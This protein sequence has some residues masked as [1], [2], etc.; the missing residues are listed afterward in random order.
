M[1]HGPMSTPFVAR[2]DQ[3]TVLLDALDRAGR[4][5]PGAVL[6][7]GDAG[8]GKSALVRHLAGLAGARGA[9]VV[10]AHCVDLGEIGLPYLP[11]AEAVARL[12]E[13]APEVVADVGRE[14]PALG[15]LLPGARPQ[16]PGGADGDRLQVFDA[17]A[18][19]LG[20]VGRPD[21]PLL[22]VVEDA[23]WADASSRD[24][25][26][27]LVSRL[28]AEHVVLVVTYRTDDLH[29]RHP[30]RPVAAELARHP[31]V[32]RVDLPPFDDDELRAFAVALTGAEPPAT[33]LRRVTERSGGNAYYAQELLESDDDEL[34]GS[35][36]DV[37]RARLEQLDPA[38]VQLARAAS[39]A[40]RRVAEP[41]LRVV[42]GAYDPS[43]GAPTV[44]D[45]TLRD[46]VGHHVLAVEDGQL[47]FRHALLGEAV[48]GDLLPGELA[49]LHRAYVRVMRDRP[50]L[51]SPAEIAAHA[52]LVPDLPTVLTASLE[53]ADAAHAL[54]APQE[55]LRHLEVALRVWDAVPEPGDRVDVLVRAAAA[56]A[57]AGR[58]DR[59]VQHA[60]TALAETSGDDEPRLRTALARH[61]LGVGRLEEAL[62]QTT[63]ALTALPPTATTERAH[64]LATHARSLVY[65]ERAV[66]AF[67]AT[68]E[69][70]A[71]ARTVSAL[72]AE[73]DALTSFALLVADDD[74][75]RADA[76]L[77]EA[78][79]RARSGQDA[80]T[81]LRILTNM[82]ANRYESA[83]LV[84]TLAV[85]TA[86]A[87]RAERAG[88]AGSPYGREL[89]GYAVLAGYV[90][91]DLRPVSVPTR[92]PDED[93]GL[94]DLVVLYRAAARGD[95]DVLERCLALEP[96]WGRDG[97]IA[98]IAGGCAVDTFAWQGRTDEAV[99]YAGRVVA[100]LEQ[101]WLPEFFGGLW[102]SALALSALADAAADA[103]VH[104]RDP[105]D[106]VAA[107]AVWRDRVERTAGRPLPPGRRVGPE[108]LAWTARA[109][110]EA[111]RLAGPSVDDPA[112]WRAVVEAFGYGHRYEAARSRFRL[113]EALLARGERD[114]A[115]REAAVVLGESDE[116]GARPLAAAV[117][118]L[119]RRGRLAVPGGEADRAD[120]LT[121][122][123]AEVLGLAARGM[124][125]NQIGR[126][127]FISGKTV[128]VHMSRV[129]AKLG[130]SGRA[131]AVAIGARRGLI[132]TADTP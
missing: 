26:R 31:R 104:G 36:A 90:Q 75:A 8:V 6:L 63:L 88:L 37:L 65:L 23:H 11:F 94:L 25:L 118:D 54:L 120:V 132:D 129:L 40:G 12:R 50:E 38:V 73:S 14:R 96:L 60:R 80:M 56:A 110:A 103:R 66:E 81:E 122:R 59:A 109:R 99:A 72:D 93:G 47:A 121:A 7:A 39:V 111:A 85:A 41:L 91:G 10:V 61:L 128:S 92:A 62:E 105:A 1:V 28:L 17:L 9:L 67:E 108:G 55:E 71:V 33:T 24:V 106:L 46:A 44:F 15:L 126:A 125:N 19:L 127:M 18:A 131:E 49:A 89:A 57:A 113:A 84:G 64:T 102:L 48:L 76:L 45:A 13:L 119:A 123:E 130:A 112:T 27:F 35:L 115:A 124:S 20:A 77:E 52:L 78:L 87:Q 16:P 70:L 34:P 32:Q 30:W 97:M 69:A 107:G 79:E 42:A 95:E 43:L 5:A 22:L 114:A 29:R 83:D 100:E 4:G 117:R 82:A 101:R 58:G 116:M 74:A 86:G 2:S 3:V 51:G 21:R 53:A 68:Q 98:L